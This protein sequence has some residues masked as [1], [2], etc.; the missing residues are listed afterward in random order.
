MFVCF[1]FLGGRDSI[2]PTWISKA[3]ICYV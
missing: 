1:F 3:V 2:V